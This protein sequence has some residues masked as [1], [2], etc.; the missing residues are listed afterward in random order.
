MNKFPQKKIFVY[1]CGG[2]GNQLFQFFFARYL[3]LKY[4]ANLYLD[5]KSGFAIDF[6]WKNK[7]SLKIK[8]NK[9]IFLKN[10]TIIFF[11]Y[12]FVKIF[13]RKKIFYNFFSSTLIDETSLKFFNKNLHNI[14]FKKNIYL[15]GF[16]QSHMYFDKYSKQIY[17]DINFSI[18]N[19]K[20]LNLK[21]KLILIIL[22]LLD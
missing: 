17:D 15:M 3:A 10:F 2:L 14:K 12:R 4:K 7:F 1:L 19:K 8:K 22:F 6:K 13:I 5:T 20:I 9:N 11:L 18:S 21:K 16:Y